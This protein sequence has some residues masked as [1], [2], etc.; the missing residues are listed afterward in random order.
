[1]W[2]EPRQPEQVYISGE[3]RFERSPDME[4]PPIYSKDD[5]LPGYG[6]VVS[7]YASPSAPTTSSH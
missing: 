5:S 1:M 4:A 6:E 7:S 2:V 3:N